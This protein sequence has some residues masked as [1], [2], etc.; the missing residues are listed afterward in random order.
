MLDIKDLGVQF[1]INGSKIDILENIHI[2][3]K[4]GEFVVIL[5]HSGCGKST[6]LKIIAGLLKETTGKILL[7]STE[8]FG[9]SKER[10]MVFQEHR[11]LPWLTIEK[12]VDIA[13]KG[14]NKGERENKIN[15][16]L[17]LVGLEKFKNAYPHQV[18]GGMA[19][20]AAIAR[21]LVNSPEIVLLDEPF[22][23]LDALTK[24]TLQKEVLRIWQKEKN[25]M[26]MV[27][28][29]I[30]EAIFLADRI[31]LMTE[32]PGT[33]EEIINVDLSRPR[34]RGNSDFARIKKRIYKHFFSDDIA[35]VEY[36]I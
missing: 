22:G 9:P 4:D 1:N 28:H 26:I 18:S 20:R 8:I 16:Y 30:D 36:N 35:Q 32:R 14:S 3:V 12:N 23:A 10:A 25:T 13:L 29:D 24:I 6:L 2:E 7:N 34:D 31:V 33:I 27:T 19:Q 21:A 15:E 17:S 5:G 11:L